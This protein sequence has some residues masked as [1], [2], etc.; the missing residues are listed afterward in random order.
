M[1]IQRITYLRQGGHVYKVFVR[2]DTIQGTLIKILLKPCFWHIRT[3]RPRTYKEPHISAK[4][5]TCTKFLFVKTRTKAQRIKPLYFF[6]PKVL[7]VLD[8]PV[9]LKRASTLRLGSCL[10]EP[11]IKKANW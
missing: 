2:E 3:D 8:F 9:Q 4:G 5:A 11:L 7:S 10:H 6:V 1:H